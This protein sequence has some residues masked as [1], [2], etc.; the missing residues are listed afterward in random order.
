MLMPPVDKSPPT[1]IYSVSTLLVN[2]TKSP[3]YNFI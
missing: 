2:F 1:P 3:T